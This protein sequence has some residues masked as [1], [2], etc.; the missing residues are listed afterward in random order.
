MQDR[1]YQ[2]LNLGFRHFFARK[3]LF[4][5]YASAYVLLPGGFGT[6]DELAEILTLVQ[7]G[8]TRRIPIVLVDG[9]FWDGLIQWFRRRFHPSGDFFVARKFLISLRNFV[10]GRTGV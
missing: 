4:V 5:K 2:D 7:T 10:P 3:V 9:K 6:L 8:K 1:R